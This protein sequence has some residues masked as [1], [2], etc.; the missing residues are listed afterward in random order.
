M[1]GL[2]EFKNYTLLDNISIEGLESLLEE[3]PELNI[4]KKTTTLNLRYATLPNDVAS[5]WTIIEWNSEDELGED[6]YFWLYQNISNWLLGTHS[7][8]TASRCFG[9]AFEENAPM[10]PTFFSQTDPDSS[11][12]DTTV[13]I[14]EEENFSY[15]LPSGELEIDGEVDIKFDIV[16]F[17]LDEFDF[18]LD[19]LVDADSF[20]WVDF[21]ITLEYDE[22]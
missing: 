12:A 13:G 8:K 3:Y 9:L 17:L 20:E 1:E 18:E 5:S 11:G 4:G 22:L 16:E 7:S 6:V 21:P 2:R 19:W 10:Q 14:Y 15:Y